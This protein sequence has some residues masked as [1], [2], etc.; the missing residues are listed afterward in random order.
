MPEDAVK[1]T[2][3]KR[4]GLTRSLIAELGEPD[5]H[6]DNPN[7]R[8]G[9]P[10][11][12][13]AVPRVEAFLRQHREALEAAEQQ[14]GRRKAAA[15]RGAETRHR[16]AVAKLQAEP[17]E[18]TRPLPSRLRVMVERAGNFVAAQGEPDVGPVGPREVRETVAEVYTNYPQLLDK[19][20]LR[21]GEGS[22]CEALRRRLGADVERLLAEH[23]GRGWSRF[24]KA[25]Q[26]ADLRTVEHDEPSRTRVHLNPSTVGGFAGFGVRAW[27]PTSGYGLTGCGRYPKSW[28]LVRTSSRRS[29]RLSNGTSPRGEATRSG[30]NAS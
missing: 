11:G 20:A 8:S 17:L 12:L 22:D 2:L 29:S 13:Y 4:F 26:S 30:G 9:P 28:R 18:L 15:A 25:G 14:R 27:L 19:F 7:R 24:V 23:Y 5:L 10:A 21:H 3:R 6:T 16:R 1:A